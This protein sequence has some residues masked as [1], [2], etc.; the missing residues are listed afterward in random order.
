[1][2]IVKFRNGDSLKVSQEVA[3]LINLRLTLTEGA[4]QWQ[5]FSDSKNSDVVHII[6][7][8]EIIF[9]SDSQ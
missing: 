6:N 3:N 8:S 5:T 9:I 4:K 1:M 7:M 2:K